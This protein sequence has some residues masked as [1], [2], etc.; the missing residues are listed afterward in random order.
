MSRDRNNGQRAGGKPEE[1][2]ALVAKQGES[3]YIKECSVKQ[4]ESS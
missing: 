2:C 1:G 4:G 3:R